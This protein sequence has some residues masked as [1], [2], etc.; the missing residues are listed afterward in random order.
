MNVKT[1]F[2]H[3]DLEEEIYM[4][5]PEGFVVKGKK[6]LVCKLKRD[7]YGLKKSPRMWYQ[8]FE[9]YILSLGFV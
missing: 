8:K 3:G 4:K 2:L 9:T 5:H 6:D 7:L 1:V